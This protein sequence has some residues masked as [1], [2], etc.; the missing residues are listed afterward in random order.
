MLAADDEAAA[1]WL[2]VGAPK[3]RMIAIPGLKDNFW[4][5]GD[6]GPCG[7][8]SEIFYDMGPAASD[9]GHTDC[10]FPCDCG[11]YVEIWNLVFM[12]FNRDASRQPQS[13]AE[14]VGRHRHGPGTHD[15]G[16]RRRHQQLRHGSVC[17]AH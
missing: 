12:Q 1:L 15:R 14:T 4:A 3:D 8:C 10:Q 13:P 7:P 6:T 17:S 16:P 2:N 9:Q 5:M 11:R